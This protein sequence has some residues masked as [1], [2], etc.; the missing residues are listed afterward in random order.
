[1]DAELLS[2]R[3]RIR[4]G[5][6]QGENDLLTPVV[7]FFTKGIAPMTHILFRNTRR[8]FTLVELLAT[9]AVL[10]ILV[11]LL[12]P[13]VQGAREADAR[14]KSQNNLKQIGIAL[15]N[16][17]AANNNQFPNCLPKNAPFFFCGQTEGKPN[18]APKFK[19]GLLSF[20]EG[21]VKALAAPADVNLANAAKVGD[22]VSPCC[23]SI[24]EHWQTLSTSGFLTLP[25]TFQRGTSQS[26]GAAEMTTQDVSY[27]KIVPFALKPYA[28]AV[29]KKASTTA[30]SFEPRGCQVVL[31]DG[32]VRLV[33]K[34][35]NAPENGD[36]ILA[37][38][39]NILT[40]FSKNW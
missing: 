37:Q 2:L 6:G 5:Q 4:H 9:F 25:A 11:G 33:P 13:A 26:I 7:R 32:S 31:V 21:D 39:P 19:N 27:A 17:A 14:A 22:E 40:N 34:E 20:M 29:L 3:P 10:A 15:N 1:M 12:L 36:F 16:Y 24:P 30:N 28:P 38:Q 18:A 35:A 23:Y 8:A